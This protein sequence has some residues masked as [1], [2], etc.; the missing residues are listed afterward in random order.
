MPKKPPNKPIPSPAHLSDK[1]QRL[2]CEIVPRRARSPERL[3]LL[4]VALKALDRCDEARAQI[5]AD[6][7]TATTKTT[8]AIHLHPLL[9]VEKEARQSF[10]SAWSTLGLQ[11]YQTI[12]GMPI[13]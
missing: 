13:E 12:D 6:G 2:W 1:S 5:A 4:T 7:M 9:R 11:W 10:L 8:G 3:A